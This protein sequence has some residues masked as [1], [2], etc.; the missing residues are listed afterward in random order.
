MPPRVF[1]VLPHAIAR[2]IVPPHERGGTMRTKALSVE[3]RI[4]ELRGQ[5]VMLSADL[6]ELYGV[7]ARALMQAV[8]RNR[9]RFPSDFMFQLSSGEWRILKSQSV[10][11]SWGGARRAR[12]YAF[13]EQGVAMLASVLR[14]PRAAAVN[15][16]IVRA[17]VRLRQ[18]AVTIAEL[19]RRIV[20]L[21]RRYD[22]RFRVVFQALR[23]LMQPEA[24]PRRVIGFTAREADGGTARARVRREVRRTGPATAARASS[25]SAQYG[26]G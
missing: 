18:A 13:T 2:T 15:V 14:S 26:G 23:G 17:F 7:P 20:A 25:S 4:H 6:A 12:P 19:A 9:A 1:S 22:E 3:S 24:P 8:K 5:R 16:E 21:E 11:S 10:T